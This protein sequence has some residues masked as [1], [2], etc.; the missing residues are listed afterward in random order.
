MPIDLP[1]LTGVVPYQAE[2]AVL[3]LREAIESMSASL[4]KRIDAIPRTLTLEEIQ[5]ALSASGSHPLPTAGLLNTLPAQSSPVQPSPPPAPSPIP[6][7]L[8]TVQA[9]FAATPVDG[10]ST[11]EQLFRFAQMVAWQ[12]MLLGTDPPPLAVGLLMQASG[13]GTFTCAGV[14]YASFRI[15]YNNGGNIKI[16]TGSFQPQWTQESDVPLTDYHVPTDP[17]GP[18]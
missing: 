6:N 1:H 7:H 14:T 9:V 18:C 15:C 11:P 3:R 5:Q 10:T 4:H 13:D 16:L 17:A 8:A 12:I 2:Q